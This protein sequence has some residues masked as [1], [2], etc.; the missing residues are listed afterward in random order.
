MPDKQRIIPVNIEDQMKSAYIDYSMS[1]IVSRALPDVR[2][3]LKPVHRR[4][5]YGMDQ[6]GL[7][8]RSSH[9]KSARIVGEVLGKYHPHGDS[10]V[11]DTMVRMAQDWSLRY[12]LVDGQGNFGSMDGDSPAAMRYTEARM[13]RISDSILGD[14]DKDT[15]DFQLNFD[16]TL[17]EP[18][19]L[20]TRIPNLL[21]NGASGIAVGMATNMMPHNLNEVVDGIVATVDNPEISID[22]LMNYIKAPDFP[23]GGI[24][25]GIDGVREAFR[26]G[27]GKVVLRGRAEVVVDD[28]DRETII[29]TEI[30]YQVNKA[31]L[32]AKIAELVN[33]GKITGVSNVQ[34]LSDRDGLRIAV[35]IKRDAMGSI[36]LSYLYKY[37]ALQT[38]FGVNNVCLV[39]GRPM[40]LN[41]KDMIEEFILFRIEVIQRRTQYELNK[42]LARAHILIGLLIAL[43]YLDEVIAL[44]RASATPEEAKIGLMKGEFIDDKKAFWAKF[45]DLVKEVQTGEFVV[46]DGNVLSE[47]QAKAILDMRLQKL[48][49]L[50]I[51]KIREEYDEIKALIDDLKDILGSESRQR[52]IVKEELIDIKTRFGDERRSEISL[53]TSDISITDMIA[54]EDVVVTISKLGYIKRTLVNEYRAQSRG[55]RGSRGSKTRDKDFVE[56]M[57]IASNHNYLMLFTEQ[58]RC[59]WLRIY[60]IPEAGKNSAGRVIQNILAMPKDD[61]VRAYISVADLTDEEFLEQHSI[62]FAT[63][64]GIVKKTNLEAYSRP[65]TNGINAISINE[66]D[67]LI[68]AKLTNGSSH[69]FL[70]TSK[71]Q[72]IH[73][74]EEKVRNM[75]RTATGVR[76]IS[77]NGEDDSVIGMVTI[78]HELDADK[79]ILVV[80][81]QGMGKR[82]AFDDYR[83]TNR[84]GKGVRTMKVTEKTGELVAL[85]AV[86]DDEDLMITN[87]SGILIRTT[88]DELRVMG[89]STQGVKLIRLEKG[90]AIADVA[91][92]P[93][94]EDEEE[95]NE[96]E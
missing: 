94:G 32:V 66:D 29:I 93:A 34:D 11:Y 91:V 21:V 67:Q 57:F 38:S 30:P 39:N 6:L 4:V 12:P 61:N 78:D 20:P 73:F 5:L 9:K 46:E 64:K 58:G 2:D 51:D 45:G 16:D 79:T 90:D 96:E 76:G 88:M 23:T 77:L 15:V 75:G 60:E 19:V 70:A 95:S 43:D 1:V 24:I 50:E 35:E 27:R 13:E 81:S 55:G 49:G 14:L 10:S 40:T 72:A 83:I 62:I 80:S 87:R 85:K 54:D 92:V 25:Y 71:G 82:S 36:V 69:V 89:R 52:S 22:E 53:D 47:W 7:S 33:E 44:I 84:G 26:T 42:A 74:E 48:T 65:R 59:F 18:A 68:E 28:N 63:K 86:T 17:K 31:T 8:F 41:L 37:T 3:G 56:H